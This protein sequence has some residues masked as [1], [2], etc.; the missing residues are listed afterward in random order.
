MTG[1]SFLFSFCWWS[2]CRSQTL[3]AGVSH[4][5]RIFWEGCWNWRDHC[6]RHSP[7]SQKALVD[8]GHEGKGKFYH[9]PW[10]EFG[11]FLIPVLGSHGACL[12]QE[13]GECPSPGPGKPGHHLLFSCDSCILVLLCFC[14][15]VCVT[16]PGFPAGFF[17]P[18]K[19]A[20]VKMSKWL[21]GEMIIGRLS[22]KKA[23]LTRTCS[24]RDSGCFFHSCLLNFESLLLFCYTGGAVNAALAFS[25]TRL[26]LVS[27]PT[28]MC[29]SLERVYSS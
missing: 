24:S 13:A 22:G 9:L 12:Q 7:A 27:L 25:K 15:C 29:R 17:A 1:I 16:S 19:T 4:N 6:R 2:S 10:W 23:V 28:S 5:P 18:E 3:P 20:S 11:C 21:S 8:A 26:V 14:M